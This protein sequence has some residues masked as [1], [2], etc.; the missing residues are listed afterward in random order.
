MLYLQFLNVLDTFLQL[1]ARI[2]LL[3]ALP[4]AFSDWAT[5]SVH[6]VGAWPYKA[7][8]EPRI[9]VFR[10]HHFLQLLVYF[11]RFEI[12]DGCIVTV[13]LFLHSACSTRKERLI[14]QFKFVCRIFKNGRRL[15]LGLVEVRLAIFCS[16]C[17]RVVFVGAYMAWHIRENHFILLDH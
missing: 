11:E 13:K 1:V 8:L 3:V 2:F 14:P 16:F 10:Y 7:R 17:S 5:Q 6:F 12:R 15:G 4:E 9:I